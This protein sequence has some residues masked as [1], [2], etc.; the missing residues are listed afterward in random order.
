VKTPRPWYRKQNDTWYIIRDGTQISLCKGKDKKADAEKVY[1]RLVAH[2]D[3][4]VPDATKL[5]VAQ[6]CDL[7]LEFSSRHHEPS[8]YEWYRAF[9]EDLCAHYG[10]LPAL[11]LT[12]FHISRWL[13]GHTGWGDGSRRGAICAAKRAFSWAE[14]E[15]LLP[16]NPIK[17]V[18]KP[19]AR[20]RDCIR[21]PEERKFILAAIKDKEF[22][23]FVFA[24]AFLAICQEIDGWADTH[25]ATRRAVDAPGATNRRVE[26]SSA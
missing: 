15:G 20:S 1:F 4:R 16:S 24:I 6:V 11:Q 21:S 3:R 13:D 9:Q 18:R 5:T 10:S 8:S 7:F 2:D 14:T 25:I 12:P 22:K 26:V 17:N 19:N 23:V